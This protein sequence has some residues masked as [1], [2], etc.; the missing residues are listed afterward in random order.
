MGKCS[1][2]ADCSM[3]SSDG[4]CACDGCTCGTVTHEALAEYKKTHCPF[5]DCPCGEGC[6]CTDCSCGG[7]TQKT[8]E[9]WIASAKK[10]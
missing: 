1:K 5:S 4:D 8:E 7:K 9:Q 10:A 3:C 2:W 6:T